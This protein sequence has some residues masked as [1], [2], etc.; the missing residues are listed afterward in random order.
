MLADWFYLLPDWLNLIGSIIY[1]CSACM[2]P[3]QFDSSGFKTEWFTTVQLLEVHTYVYIQTNSYIN[4]YI[5]TNKFIH[6]YI[7][8]Y[9]HTN[10]LM[11][12]YI[13]AYI[14][15]NKLMHTYIHTYIRMYV[16]VLSTFTSNFIMCVLLCNEQLIAVIIEFVAAIGWLIQWYV[17]Y[18]DDL[19]DHPGHCIGRCVYVLYKHTYIHTHRYIYIYIYRC[20]VVTWAQMCV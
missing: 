20:V 3:Y 17:G 4:T 18:N 11:H 14:H 15:T 9:I 5:Q 8:T 16:Y 10:K 13:Y 2:Y 7:H 1:L 6:A 19:R 12:A